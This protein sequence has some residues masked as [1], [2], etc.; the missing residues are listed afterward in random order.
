MLQTSEPDLRV[1]PVVKVL[2]RY[3]FAVVAV[4]MA[5]LLDLVFSGALEPH[6]YAPF[7]F[8]IILVAFFGDL[9]SSL[10]ATFLAVAATNYSEFLSEHRLRLDA[11]DL[12][13]L[14]MFVTIAM[15]ISLLTT[16]RRRPSMSSS[17]SMPSCANSIAPRIDS[18]PR[19]RTSCE[20][21]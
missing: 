21:P 8:A 1:A 7:V 14:A 19:F 9:G 20:P 16:R 18:S 5:L 3:A 2:A 15:S 13:Q 11:D 6:R 12:V 10:L 17:A 4:G